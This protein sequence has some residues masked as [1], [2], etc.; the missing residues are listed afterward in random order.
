M[1]IATEISRLQS[2]KAAI[3]SA[4]EGKGVTV[5]SSTLLDGYA[6]LISSIP[7]GGGS[8]RLVTGTFTANSTTG[9]QSVTIPYTGTGYP[10]AAIVCLSDGMSSTSNPTWSNLI[11]RY[12]IGFWAMFKNSQSTP[13]T[14]AT[15]GDA[16]SAVTMTTYKNSTTSATTYARGGDIGTN[17]FSSSNAT[18]ASSTCVR[19]NS[20]TAMSVYIAATGTGLAAGLDFDYIIVY[21]S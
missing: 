17:T 4:I 16:N 18:A 2:A 12:A 11:H 21:S 19:F 6:A 5:P 3:K 15:S 14:Y 20:A 9:V 7:T 8:S 13:P 10:I 1:S